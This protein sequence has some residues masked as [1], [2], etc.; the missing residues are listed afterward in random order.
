MTLSVL[1]YQIDNFWHEKNLKL[2][3]NPFF[4]NER[5]DFYSDVWSFSAKQYG[6]ITT[7]DFSWFDSPEYSLSSIATYIK[8]NCEYLLSSKAY[9]KLACLEMLTPSN[10]A[11]VQPTYQMMLHLFAFFKEN[12]VSI[13]NISLM[14]PFWTSFMGRTISPHG[15]VNRVSIPS[16]RASIRRVSFHKIRN[17]L[18]AL[19][20]VGVIEPKLT[21]KIVEKSLNDVCQTQ[22]STT[23]AEYKKGGSF[24]FLGLEL[25]Q[26]YVDYLNGVYQQNFLYVLVCKKTFEHCINKYSIGSFESKTNNR[27]FNVM[28]SAVFGGEDYAPNSHTK[29]INH[30]ALKVNAENIL[31]NEYLKHFEAVMSLKDSNIEALVYELGLSTRSDAMELIR[32]LML[33]KHLGLDGH[34]TPDEVWQGYLLSLDQT[35][36]GSESLNETLV[37]DLYKKMQLIIDKKKLE[38]TQFLVDIQK[39][40]LEQISYSENKTY[41]NFK[42]TLNITLYAMTSLVV[43]WTGYRRSEFGFPLSAIRPEPNLDI[44]DNAHVPF[45]FKLKWLVPK[46]SGS[47]KINREITSQC[48]QIAAQLN[49]VFGSSSNEPCLYRLENN[50]FKKEKL[51]NSDVCINNRVIANWK[52]F[53]D[54]YSP[55]NDVVLLDRLIQKEICLL[56]NTEQEKLRKLSLMYEVGS[57][58][59][60]NLLTCAKEVKKDWLRLSN[61]SFNGARAQERFKSSLIKYM[62]DN[63]VD[64]IK[65]QQIIDT[66]LSDE[67]KNLLTSNSI[68]LNDKKTVM[69][70][71]SEILEGVRYPSAHAFRHIWAEAVLTRYQGDVGAVIRHQFAHLDNSFF[72]AYLRDKDARGLMA[73]AKQR[74]LNTIVETLIIESNHIGERYIGGVAQFVKKAV[75]LTQVKDES[76]LTESER[77]ALSEA[78]AGRII[79]IQPSRFATCI[80][81]DGGESRAKCAQMGSLNPQDAKLEFCLNCMNAYISEGNIRGIWQ[82]VQ[83]MVKEA[84]QPNGIGF[85]LESHLPALTSSLRRIKELRNSRNEESV[86]K[87]LSAIEDAVDSIKRKMAVEAKQYGYE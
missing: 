32:V 12:N 46:T 60:E 67:T 45:C 27:L 2:K 57:A 21:F 36:L 29:G 54:S 34:K 63:E 68:D 61:S 56:T 83:P 49:D 35:F 52:G 14:E 50:N 85:L 65:H 48:Y 19:G 15:L 51:N 7:I 44:L 17:S 1:N 75:H 23:L 73:S 20:V 5:G 43:A 69:D 78:I 18:K 81:R 11:Y 47:T 28:L 84:M 25:G 74:Y 62:K 87:I 26:Y 13:L 76:E 42:T 59:Y 9:A 66:Y 64:N 8:D 30:I 82:T 24:N 4:I 22:Y 41:E 80:P 79:D 58:R 6:N 33:Q 86:D 53:V 37:E 10:I 70:I 31:F 16:Y 3:A 55:F 38:Q 39:W 40:A 72:M 77:R 71:T